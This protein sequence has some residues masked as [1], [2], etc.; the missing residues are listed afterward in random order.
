MF[1]NPLHRARLEHGIT[2]EEVASRTCLSPRIVQLLD[3]GRFEELPGGLYARSYVRSVATVVGVQP[4][5]ALRDLFD[6]LPADE[7]PLPVLREHARA[8]LPPFVQDV[9]EWLRRHRADAVDRP[10]SERA[11][12]SVARAVDL[13]VLAVFY[14]AVLRLTAW[15]AGVGVG[16]ALLLAGFQVA[17]VCSLAVIPYFVVLGGL[18]GQSV[19]RV[20]GAVRRSPAA[21]TD[22]D[23]AGWKPDPGE[24]GAGC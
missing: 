23:R 6:R 2:L 11:Q 16:D 1:M 5:L 15:T 14:A 20:L 13:S 21:P 19:G 7:D 17:A 3:A 10:M 8:A 9:M 4:E 18:G 22:H 24:L 12:R